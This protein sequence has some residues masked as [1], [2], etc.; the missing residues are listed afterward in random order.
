MTVRR[1]AR[2]IVLAMCLVM[3][4]TACLRESDRSRETVALPGPDQESWNS[5][6]ILTKEGLRRAVILSRHLTKSEGRGVVVMD[7]HVTADLYSAEGQ[8]MSKLTSDRARV[9]E[10]TDDLMAAG[11]VVVVSD[12][13]VTLRTDSLLWDSRRGLVTS[14]GRVRFT[15]LSGDTLFGTGFESNVDLTRWK[16]LRPSGV[17]GG[18]Q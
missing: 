10:A 15:T 4:S 17:V 5:E 9:L 7:G 12:S 1:D 8:H 3:G 14:P 16:I 6:I 11:R 13:G 2:R 18:L